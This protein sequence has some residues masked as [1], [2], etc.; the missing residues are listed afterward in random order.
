[1]GVST[2]HVVA[3]PD[4]RTLFVSN[5]GNS[6]LVMD[7]ATRTV[8]TAIPVGTVSNGMTLNKSG[9]RLYVSLVLTGQVAEVT[10]LNDS[11]T[12]IF[13]TGGVPQDLVVANGVLYVANESGT[14]DAWNLS[15]GMPIG[16]TPIGCGGFGMALSPDGVQL[17]ISQPGC[18]TVTVVDR[19][20]R[21]V[22]GSIA[23]TGTPRK[24]GF[25]SSG[26]TAAIANEGGW[27]DF[28]Q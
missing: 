20:S 2:F 1:V 15:T 8:R 3:T 27:V 5:N 26:T 7:V 10:T 19:A 14:L 11:V 16:S 24:V 22:V 18:G 17:Y 4:D 25:N 23:T 28:V 13:A 6:V 21:A 12:R 9:S